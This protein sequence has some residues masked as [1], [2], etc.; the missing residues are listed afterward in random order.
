MVVPKSCT[1]LYLSYILAQLTILQGA[2]IQEY[3]PKRWMCYIDLLINH[4]IKQSQATA[5]EKVEI[6]MAKKRKTSLN[7]MQNSWQALVDLKN[8]VKYFL[9]EQSSPSELSQG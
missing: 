4:N 8:V 6:R 1:F 7:L 3:F 2:I 9:K 5:D